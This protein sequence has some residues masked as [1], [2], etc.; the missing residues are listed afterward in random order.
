MLFLFKLYLSIDTHTHIH[1]P[2]AH[3]RKECPVADKDAGRIG[4]CSGKDI[5]QDLHS[6]NSSQ[7]NKR[8]TV[9]FWMSAYHS[10]LEI[11]LF[12]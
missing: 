10:V 8:Y 5:R 7:L 3:F 2:S 6:I 4:N 1:T 9:E 12:S 11:C